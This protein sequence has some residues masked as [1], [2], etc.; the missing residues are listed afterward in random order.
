[1]RRVSRL[2]VVAWCSVGVVS[3]ATISGLDQI[4]E[5]DCAPDCGAEMYAADGSTGSP[6]DGP[7][8]SDR[9][10][11]LDVALDTSSSV[12][13]SVDASFDVEAS[14]GQARETAAEDASDG[15]EVGP[16]DAASEAHDSG[17]PLD[18]GVDA[19]PEAEAGCGPLNTTVNCGACGA[20]CA[21]APSANGASCNGTVCS[22]QCNPGYLDCNASTAPNTDGCECQTPGAIGATCCGSNCPIQ[23]VTGFP[24]GVIPPGRD[25]TFYDCNTGLSEQVAMEACTAYSGSPAY[26]ATN[27]S[28]GFPC[29]GADGGTNGDLVVCNFL[30]GG[31]SCVCWDYQGS[32]AGW[33]LNTGL[34]TMCACPTGGAGNFAYH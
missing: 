34:T 27:T 20:K 6:G 13:S 2:G 25:Q 21:H 10:V 28:F 5:I 30:A 8:P 4:K 7:S 17:P 29:I 9:T 23:H 16:G 31:Q 33:A 11:P 19:A 24:T 12:D 32:H 15:A 22:Y 1:V 18:T 3:C 14:D 26:C